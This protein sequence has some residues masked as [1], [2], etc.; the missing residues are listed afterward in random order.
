MGLFKSKEEKRI[1]WE[2][3]VRRG[4]ARIKR[5]IASLEKN[6]GGTWRRRGARRASA[7]ATSTSSCGGP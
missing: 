1:E 2:I 4:L 6:E 3:T 7:P 5:Q